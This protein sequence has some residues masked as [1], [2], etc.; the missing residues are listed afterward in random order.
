MRGDQTNKTNRDTG[1]HHLARRPNRESQARAAGGKMVSLPAN[2]A[3][4]E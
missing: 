3:R 2:D 1:G 4:I